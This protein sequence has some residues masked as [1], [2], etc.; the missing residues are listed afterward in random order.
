RRR[1][2][3]LR[4]RRG[5]PDRPHP[6]PDDR[7]PFISRATCRGRAPLLLGAVRARSGPRSGPLRHVPRVARDVSARSSVNLTTL[8]GDARAVRRYFGAVTR[9]LQSYLALPID[10]GSGGHIPRLDWMRARAY[11]QLKLHRCNS[12]PVSAGRLSPRFRTTTSCSEGEPW[13][14]D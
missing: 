13:R 3:D 5:R 7:I 4:A 1:R 2:T 9:Y 12:F 11:P 6:D 14:S 8:R 10:T